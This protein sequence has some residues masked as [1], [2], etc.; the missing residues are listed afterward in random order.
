MSTAEILPY[1][2]P[3]P[4][5]IVQ[6]ARDMLAQ[7][8]SVA[9]VIQFRD[10][11]EA[12][13]HYL[14]KQGADLE[15]LNAAAE[16]KLWTERRLGELIPVIAPHGGDRR[17]DSRC[18]G[19]TLNDLGINK[20]QSSRWQQ[21]ATLSEDELAEHIEATKAAG[22]ELTTASVLRIV[23][24]KQS[25]GREPPEFDVEAAIDDLYERLRSVFDRWPVEHAQ[26]FAGQLEAIASRI[27]R[28]GEFA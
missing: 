17:S 22:K 19:G 21:V 24:A 8:D 12:F 6:S 15:L 2:G 7:I 20:R 23:A 18:H 27:R 3:T 16:S 14:A 4:L 13:R 1:R 5:E 25:E 28:T 10:Q 26:I 9:E 11:M